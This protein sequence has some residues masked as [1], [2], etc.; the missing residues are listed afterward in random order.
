[1]A[2]SLMGKTSREAA[3]L[4]SVKGCFQKSCE[5]TSDRG[6]ITN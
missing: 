6:Y 3:I 2:A 5:V 4:C 1:M